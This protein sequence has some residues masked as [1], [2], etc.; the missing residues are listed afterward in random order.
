[1]YGWGRGGF[2]ALSN[3]ETGPERWSDLSKVTQLLRGGDG[4]RLRGAGGG[5]VCRGR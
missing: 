2:L 4:S 3:K 5:G 1:M